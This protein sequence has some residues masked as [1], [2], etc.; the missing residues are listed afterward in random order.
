MDTIRSF[1]SFDTSFPLI[2][3]QFF[4]RSFPLFSRVSLANQLNFF[5]FFSNSLNLIFLT[6]FSHS[7]NLINYSKGIFCSHE[8]FLCSNIEI[9]FDKFDP[10]PFFISDFC[11][12]NPIFKTDW[13]P[14]L[15]LQHKYEKIG[16]FAAMKSKYLYKNRILESKSYFAIFWI[17][18]C[19][20][21]SGYKCFVAGREFLK[22]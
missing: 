5:S 11:A 12:L 4:N 6:F 9:L 19:L 15:L 3:N 20:K 2:I 17:K 16:L 13:G 10:I 1:R 18:I 7:F 21:I 22:T 8:R 14:T